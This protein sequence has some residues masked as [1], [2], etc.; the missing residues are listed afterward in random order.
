LY[1][2]SITVNLI[3]TAN[4]INVYIGIFL[5]RCEMLLEQ[6]LYVGILILVGVVVLS[7]R[8]KAEGSRTGYKLV[9]VLLGILLGLLPLGEYSL[10]SFDKYFLKSFCVFLLIVLL[11]ELS[12]RLNPDN[13][14]LTFENVTMFFMILILNILVLGVV[15]PLFISINFIHGVI[16][17]IVLSSVEY[18]LVDQLKSEGDLANP[19]IILFAFSLMVFYA[20]E[21]NAFD[22]VSYFLKYMITGIGM[23]VLSGIIVFRC[24]KNQYIAPANELGMVAVAVATYI[25]TEQLGGSGLFAVLVLGTFFGNSFV[26]KTT[27]MHSFSPFIFK[28]LEM[29]IFLMIGFVAAIHF[30]EGLWWKSFILFV[31]YLVLRLLVIHLYYRHYSLDNKFLMVFA[32]KGMILGVAI[33]VLGV[34]ESVE[35]SLLIVML[36][37]M[38]YSLL[39]GIFV[40]YIEQRKELRLDKVLKLLMTARFGRAKNSKVKSR[41]R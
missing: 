36:F 31:I 34:Y 27:S 28:T 17:A 11:F 19:F 7:L 12:V 20:V 18:F 26:R 33:L 4:L 25:I 15:T 30:R 1:Q 5:K 37:I 2:A 35:D 10:L 40:E 13:I 3:I 21:G 32:P 16:F 41:T 8:R 14:K 38:L 29:L 23:G 9:L 24:L 39:A 6:F 22:K